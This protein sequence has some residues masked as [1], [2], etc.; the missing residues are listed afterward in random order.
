M[1]DKLT[2]DQVRSASTVKH[3][4]KCTPLGHGLANVQR[5]PVASHYISSM[6]VHLTQLPAALQVE[7]MLADVEVDANGNFKYQA[8]V[9]QFRSDA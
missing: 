1:G 6:A 5:P 7:D 8:F 3:A 2:G 4:A 9:K